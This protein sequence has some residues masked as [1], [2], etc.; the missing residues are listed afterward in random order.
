MHA[1][2][3]L[4]GWEEMVDTTI[5]HQLRTNLAKSVKDQNVNIEMLSVG[6]DTSKLKKHIAIFV[7]RMSKGASLS[8]GFGKDN[9]SGQYLTI[10]NLCRLAVRLCMTAS[11]FLT[12]D[13]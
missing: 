3:L 12:G 1:A 9:S 6:H 13:K 11:C 7:E 8:T 2:E 5:T 10:C 4:Q